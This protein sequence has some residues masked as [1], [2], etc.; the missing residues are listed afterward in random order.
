MEFRE[1]QD[2][3]LNQEDFYFENDISYALLGELRCTPDGKTAWMVICPSNINMTYIWGGR[4]GSE[5]GFY[6]EILLYN[7]DLLTSR[8]NA[9][10]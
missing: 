8:E 4:V 5:L 2:L 6:E 7:P 10:P 1:R 3:A 9:A